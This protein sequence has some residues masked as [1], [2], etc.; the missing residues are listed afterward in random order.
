M[1][2]I[3]EQSIKDWR[4]KH[5]TRLTKNRRAYKNLVNKES[6]YAKEIKQLGDLHEA[7]LKVYKDAPDTFKKEARE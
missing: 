5:T 3:Y 6:G 1:N 4:W 2:F 7:A